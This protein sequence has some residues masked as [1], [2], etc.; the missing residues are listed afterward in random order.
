MSER[1]GLESGQLL[2]NPGINISMKKG[3][4][5]VVFLD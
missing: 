1:K 4:K 3:R 5:N 2:H